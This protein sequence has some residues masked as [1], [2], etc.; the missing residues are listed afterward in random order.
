MSEIVTSGEFVGSTDVRVGYL[1][2]PGFTNATVK[3]DVVDGTAIFDGCIDMGPV[4]EVEAHT[5][6]VRAERR[7]LRGLAASGP[8]SPSDAPADTAPPVELMGVGLPTNSSFLWTNGVV[9]FVIDDALPNPARVTQ[10]IAHLEANTGIRFVARTTEANRVRFVRN[11][12]GGWSSSAVGMRGGEQ[13]I[14]LAD[15]APMGTVV[16]ECLHALGVLHEQSRC[17]RD[18]YVTINYGN[19]QDG[20]ESNFD[21]FCDGYRDYLDYDYGSIMHYPGRRS[22]RTTSRRSCPSSPASQSASATA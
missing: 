9:P 8:G 14:R 12:E 17:D 16:H 4:E 11:P 6:Q 19:I 21:R 18:Q 15:G 13:L 20:F 10:A 5:E 3:Y 22:P 7:R 2:G 1:S